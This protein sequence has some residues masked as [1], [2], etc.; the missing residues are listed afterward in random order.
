MQKLVAQKKMIILILPVFLFYAFIPFYQQ[1]RPIFQDFIKKDY[2]SLIFNSG[3]QKQIIELKNQILK[4]DENLQKARA[5]V[6]EAEKQD[7]IIKVTQS[8]KTKNK[9]LK[10]K[11]K[12]IKKADKIWTNTLPE[13]FQKYEALA[14]IYTN[15]FTTVQPK[16]DSAYYQFAQRIKQLADID[17]NLAKNTYSYALSLETTEKSAELQKVVKVMPKVISEYE[18]AYAALMGDQII[19]TWIKSEVKNEETTNKQNNKKTET[20]VEK[21]EKSHITTVNGS[22]YVSFES[23]I[24][25]QLKL[26]SDETQQL[27]NAKQ[28]ENNVLA[29]NSQID[30]WYTEIDKLRY[31][32]DT[33]K[34]ITNKESYKKKVSELEVQSFQKLIEATDIYLKVNKIKFDLYK[35]YLQTLAFTSDAQKNKVQM[36]A[37]EANTLFSIA[38]TK[39]NLAMKLQYVSDKYIKLME[40]NELEL[41]ALEKQ[42]SAFLYFYAMPETTEAIIA[43][44]E[45]VV[46]PIEEQLESTAEKT[47]AGQAEFPRSYNYS[48]LKQS[49]VDVL[50]L[51]SDFTYRVQVGAFKTFPSL[52]LAKKYKITPKKLNNSDLSVFYAGDFKSFEAINF[53]LDEVRQK[54]Y[55]DAF[56]I[57]YIN[58]QL[59]SPVQAQNAI[60]K[61]KDLYS[62]YLDVAKY[63]LLALKGN[64][65]YFDIYKAETKEAPAKIEQQ[66]VEEK[67]GGN[68]L[69]NQKGL[70]FYVQLGSFSKPD[71]PATL[72]S[73]LPLTVSKKKSGLYSMLKGPFGT[74]SDAQNFEKTV[75][76]NGISGAYIVS[77]K[78][79]KPLELFKAIEEDKKNENKTAVA[80]TEN[81]NTATSEKIAYRIQVAAY[82]GAIPSDLQKKL[83]LVAQSMPVEKFKQKNGVVLYTVG[84][85]TTYEMAQKAKNDLSKF[86]INEGFVVAF[87]GDEKIDLSE[88]RKSN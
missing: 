45:E 21:T 2:F 17:A 18:Y 84:Y 16:A 44:T 20:V 8:E 83:D 3:E 10:T 12:L 6:L 71:V 81:K 64:K 41:L 30:K 75:K 73:F 69:E 82:A 55:K 34:T 60:K 79:G 35:K 25:S 54:G 68:T 78:D 28:M 38:E 72:K 13:L 86:S 40:A 53:V 61:N 5:Y 66:S 4:T 88:A 58:T 31:Q 57:S 36:L 63:E 22:I 15:K 37:M 87:K 27:N 48:A 51:T 74:Y 7:R 46:S 29:I 49:Q 14:V 9:A 77:Y 32:A 85:Y 47:V 67:I 62:K 80:S 23:K 59:C 39:K 42:E 70:A 50:S 1:E 56:I 43:E 26:S 76:K 33:A 52:A 65:S 24:I 19:K 11:T